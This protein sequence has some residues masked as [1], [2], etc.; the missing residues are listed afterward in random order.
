M[1]NWGLLKS[2]TLFKVAQLVSDSSVSSM[3]AGPRTAVFT[4]VYPSPRAP[5]GLSGG[6]C[7]MLRMEPVP[8]S[9]SP[10]LPCSF[11]CHVRPELTGPIPE[12]SGMP[13][14]FLAQD[15]LSHGPTLGKVTAAADRQQTLGSPND[16]PAP[17]KTM[18]QR[19]TLSSLRAEVLCHRVYGKTLW[20]FLDGWRFSLIH[21]SALVGGMRSY[22][23]VQVPRIVFRY[24]L[25]SV[26]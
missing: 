3:R 6:V 8:R 24:S 9:A 20:L 15:E 17:F 12:I 16:I 25:D 18:G 21:S 5:T 7:T 22:N 23:R 2:G 1:G 11:L 26:Y 13:S 4:S 19:G 14:C 10:H